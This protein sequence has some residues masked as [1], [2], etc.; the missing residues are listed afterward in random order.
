MGTS[1]ILQPGHGSTLVA[2]GTGTGAHGLVTTIAATAATVWTGGRLV[3]NRTLTQVL[4]FPLSHCGIA[5][6]ARGDGGG[7]VPKRGVAGLRQH[8]RHLSLVERELGLARSRGNHVV[9]VTV[10][11][12]GV[13]VV[14]VVVMVRIGGHIG[15]WEEGVDHVVWRGGDVRVEVMVVGGL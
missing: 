7:W 3:W 15:V 14:R 5:D 1:P 2:S 9:G 13:M 12:V 11:G 6:R 4:S 8:G 10:H